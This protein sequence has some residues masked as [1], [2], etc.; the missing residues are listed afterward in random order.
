VLTCLVA[1][2]HAS[3]VCERAARRMAQEE[4]ANHNLL[5]ADGRRTFT[6]RMRAHQ[7]Q[8][9]RAESEEQEML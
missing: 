8:R 5:S 7:L 4:A 2:L 3:G 1:R 9:E 6:N